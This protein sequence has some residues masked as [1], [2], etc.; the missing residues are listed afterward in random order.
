[1]ANLDNAAELIKRYE[2]LRLKAYLCPAGVQT[3]GYGSTGPDI[4]L[5]MEW[6]KQQA[7]D[8]LE[9]RIEDLFHRISA[10][11]KYD[12]YD[13]EMCALI[14]FVYNLGLGAFKGSTLLKLINVDDQDAPKQIL[15]WD[16][17]A[18]RALSGLR[19]RRICEYLLY[20]QGRIATQD[21]CFG[22]IGKY[23][24]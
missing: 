10:L 8:D 7:E 21:E 13:N 24:A 1:M 5:G 22:L 17:A 23:Y 18:G 9:A 11:L 14:S 15:L 19:S 4:R 16:K 2:G 3:I 12:L 6:T 20:S